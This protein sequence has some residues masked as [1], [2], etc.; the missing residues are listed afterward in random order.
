MDPVVIAT[1]PPDLHDPGVMSRFATS[2]RL[3]RL[4]RGLREGELLLPAGDGL[5]LRDA[6]TGRDYLIEVSPYDRV[7]LVSSGP[8]RVHALGTGTGT[9]LQLVPPL[10]D[11]LDQVHDLAAAF[12]RAATEHLGEAVLHLAQDLDTVTFLLRL[13]SGSTLRL[14]R[15]LAP[16]I[17]GQ[18]VPVRS[19][20]RLAAHTLHQPDARAV[21]SLLGRLLRTALSDI[22]Q[23]T[24]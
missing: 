16:S 8:H 1:P 6:G 22:A 18:W 23:E 21:T 12:E 3:A 2:W 24:P 13:P 17:D 9:D 20:A 11:H 7:A 19:A 14:G 5:T 10:L 4:L 15:D